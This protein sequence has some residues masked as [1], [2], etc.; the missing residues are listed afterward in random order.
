MANQQAQL[1]WV[2]D[3]PV[4][5][6]DQTLYLV[7]A[8]VKK[9]DKRETSKSAKWSTKMLLADDTGEFW[10]KV[11]DGNAGEMPQSYLGHTVAF[12]IK[13]QTFKGNKYVS[14]FWELE[15]AAIPAKPP[16]ATPSPAMGTA[17]PPVFDEHGNV[18]SIQEAQKAV[19]T[20]KSIGVGQLDPQTQDRRDRGVA[21]TAMAAFLATSKRELTVNDL[22]VE[23]EAAFN[24]IKTG[25]VPVAEPDEPGA[26]DTEFPPE[27]A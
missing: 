15:K 27:G 21:I 10:V 2:F 20:Q 25:T 18:M 24:Y 22:I 16:Y 17:R 1:R 12:N 9:F 13:A 19:E 7:N 11:W 23:S 26:S 3:N 4:P 6:N 8:I 5:D 14:G